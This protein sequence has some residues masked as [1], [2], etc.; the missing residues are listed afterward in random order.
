MKQLFLIAAAGLALGLFA[1]RAAAENIVIIVN[2]SN[3]VDNITT[4]QLKKIVLGEQ[5]QWSGGRQVIVLLRNPGSPE[6]DIPLQVV[7]GMSEADFKQYFAKA[8]F[9]GSTATPP[10]SMGTAALLRQ[11]ITTLPGA[12]G[13]VEA[14]DVTDTVKAIKLDGESADSE[15]YKLK[16]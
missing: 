8:S 3:P 16:K 11:L 1:R 9:T 6:R 5:T 13:F 15:A 14:S 7:C 4:A 2:K 10:R 12:I